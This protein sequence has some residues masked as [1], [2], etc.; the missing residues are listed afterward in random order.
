MELL[1]ISC[2]IAA[3]EDARE[4]HD[5]ESRISDAIFI[6]GL[7]INCFPLLWRHLPRLLEKEYVY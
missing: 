3:M 2:S 4:L 5:E 1:D 6:I 7:K